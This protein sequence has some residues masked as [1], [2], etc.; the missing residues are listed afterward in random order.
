MKGASFTFSLE[1]NGEAFV[2]DESGRA[3]REVR[4]AKIYELGPVV[5]PAYPATTAAVAMRSYEAWMAE[6]A[7]DMDT[8]DKVERK[9]RNASAA[10]RAARLRSI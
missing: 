2:T 10:L 7:Q 4:A 8:P 5:Q 3:I 9:I 1:K 6:Q